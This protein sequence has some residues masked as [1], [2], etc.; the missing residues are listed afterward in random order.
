[1]KFRKIISPDALDKTHRA[2][3]FTLEVLI[4]E[5]RQQIADLTKLVRYQRKQL[6]VSA[7]VCSLRPL[8]ERCRGLLATYPNGPVFQVTR[9]EVE[10][11][12]ALAEKTS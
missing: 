8:I 1:M 12:A 11:V 3:A 7:M 6:A 2:R 9:E 10:L 5:Q 4:A